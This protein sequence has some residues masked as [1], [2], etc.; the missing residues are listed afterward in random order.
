MEH[1]LTYKICQIIAATTHVKMK[2]HRALDCHMHEVADCLRHKCGNLENS[3]HRIWKHSKQ[4]CGWILYAVSTRGQDQTPNAWFFR[5]EVTTHIRV[6]VPLMTGSAAQITT[7]CWLG[8]R[9]LLIPCCPWNSCK[10]LKSKIE[11]MM[12]ADTISKA[13]VPPFHLPSERSRQGFLIP[14]WI[15]NLLHEWWLD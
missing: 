8:L 14:P 2:L 12:N 3:L 15:G 13:N 6:L 5:Q 9:P 4:M 11:L 7:H 1:A 10:F